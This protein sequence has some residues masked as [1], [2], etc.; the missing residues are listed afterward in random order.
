M[1]SAIVL[2]AGIALALAA[3]CAPEGEPPPAGDTAG[4]ARQMRP[5][6]SG[7]VTR[8]DTLDGTGGRVA[9]ATVEVNPL[10]ESGSPK[11]RVAI[12]TAT[13]IFIE[14]GGVQQ[15][16]SF[17]ELRLLRLVDV[18][19]DGPVAESYPVQATASRIVVRP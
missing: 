14:D 3:A 6:I 12:T 7:T 1:R 19:F 8:L 2:G 17:D 9:T 10:E 16:A 15:P 4:A 13:R 18:W 5:D 11:A